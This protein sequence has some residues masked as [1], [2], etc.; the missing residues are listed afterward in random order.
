MNC[1]AVSDGTACEEQ[2]L[3]PF[4]FGR[5]SNGFVE[6]K[7]EDY[8]VPLTSNRKQQE[9]I[10]LGIARRT[11]KISHKNVVGGSTPQKG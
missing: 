7:N 1:D 11:K 3:H 2:G 6:W 8:I 4:H 9:H 10:L 5:G